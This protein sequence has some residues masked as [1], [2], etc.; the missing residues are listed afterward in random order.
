MKRICSLR[1]AILTTLFLGTCVSVRETVFLATH[2]LEVS[3]FHSATLTAASADRII[4]DMGAVLV[5]PDGPDDIVCNVDFLR[6]GPVRTFDTGTGS[7]YNAQGLKAVLD[8]PG[9]VKVVNEIKWCKG[10]IPDLLG[11]AELGGDSFV[12]VSSIGQRE[13]EGIAWAHEFGHNQGLDHRSGHSLLMN[14]PVTTTSRR[15]TEKDCRALSQ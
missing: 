5:T 10:L 4:A 2:V 3:R 9:R 11:C 14:Y 6:G 8:L 13:L 12:V 1:A 7:I 15:V